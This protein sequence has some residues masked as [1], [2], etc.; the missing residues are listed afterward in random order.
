[1]S[2]RAILEYWAGSD[3][4]TTR[5]ANLT[6]GNGVPRLDA[7]TVTS[8]AGGDTLTGGPGLDLFY[9]SLASDTVLN[10]DAATETFLGV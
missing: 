8:N 9:G 7:S 2:L 6:A 10:W 4:Y 3:D 5:V 1:M